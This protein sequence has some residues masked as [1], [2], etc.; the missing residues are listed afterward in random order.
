MYW[1]TSKQHHVHSARPII[2]PRYPSESQ[3]QTSSKK[4][5]RLS[6]FRRRP[7]ENCAGA[8]SQHIRPGDKRSAALVGGP[9]SSVL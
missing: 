2:A 4:K 5:R 1:A 7:H 6:G 8:G 3:A 9:S